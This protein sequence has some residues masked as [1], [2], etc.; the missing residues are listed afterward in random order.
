[1]TARGLPDVLRAAIAEAEP[2]EALGAVEVVRA[3][4]LARLVNGKDVLGARREDASDEMLSAREAAGLL[5]QS[6][7]WVYDHA[8]EL[9]AERHGRSVRVSRAAVERYRKRR[10]GR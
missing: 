3:E 10:A 5:G 7:R 9:R 4:L 2:V 1:M 6:V 8:E